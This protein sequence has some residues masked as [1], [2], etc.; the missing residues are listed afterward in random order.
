M[1]FGFRGGVEA[2][3]GSDILDLGR[4]KA[5]AGSTTGLN[6]ND[7]ARPQGH[8][9]SATTITCCKDEFRRRP[10]PIGYPPT[11]TSPLPRVT[12]PRLSADADAI[13]I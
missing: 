10:A 2:W 1:G 9:P 8:T 11:W 6:Q 7:R 3:D 12:L 4:G 5:D 13:F